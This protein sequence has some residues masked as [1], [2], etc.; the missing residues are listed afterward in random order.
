MNRGF[1]QKPLIRQLIVVILAKEKGEK[2]DETE[3]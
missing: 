3:D 1:F 2:K